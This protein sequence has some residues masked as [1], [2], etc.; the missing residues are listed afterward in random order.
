MAHPDDCECGN[1]C[2]P[3]DDVE[4]DPPWRIVIRTVGADG[5]VLAEEVDPDLPLG[6]ADYRRATRR[7]KSGNALGEDSTE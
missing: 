4:G 2:Q 1:D 5:K 6:G 3:W 7:P